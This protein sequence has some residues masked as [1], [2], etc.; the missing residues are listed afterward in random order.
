MKRR[1]CC[2]ALTGLVLLLVL[3]SAAAIAQTRSNCSVCHS[4]MEYLRQN[5]DSASRAQAVHVPD[6]TVAASAHGKLQCVECHVGFGRFPHSSGS[7]RA[8]ASC[9]QKANEPWL[10]GAH[11]QQ[12][13][14]SGA[15]CEQCHSVHDVRSAAELKT[16]RGIAGMNRQCV[17]C[18]QAARLSVKSPHAD[19][20]LCSGCHGPHDTRPAYDRDSRLWASQQ[21]QTCGTCHTEITRVWSRDDV[22]AQALLTRR[23]QKTADKQRRAPACTNCH[24]GHGMVADPDSTLVQ[25][26]FERCAECHG[27]TAGGYEDSYHGQAIELGSKRAA[28]CADCHTAHSIQ[29]ADRPTS[30]IAHANLAKTC[31]ACHGPVTAGF[32]KFDPHADHHDPSNPL[33]YW[34]YKL[35]TLLLIGTMGFFGL[36]TVLWM[37]RLSIDARN[38]RRRDK[39]RDA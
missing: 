31:G 12:P 30:S 24:G 39:G 4:E 25:A 35:M 3:N 5:T 16:K 10:A 13:E 32:L 1:Q 2:S 18:H 37:V 34:S 9:H 23:P 27:H 21:L 7:T 17:S 29:P 36:H 22:H 14:Q 6:S 33:V 8:C 11:A 19:S 38:A 26:A 20:V 15:S 28:A